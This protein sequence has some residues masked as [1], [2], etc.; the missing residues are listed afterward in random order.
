MPERD[1]TS[2][3]SDEE[4]RKRG[5]PEPQVSTIQSGINALLNNRMA[6]YNLFKF[7]AI[8]KHLLSGLVKG[9]LYFARSS[10]LNDPF[11]CRV[12]LLT[13]LENAISVAQQPARGNLEKLRGMH[14]F[15][16][17]VQADLA[18]MGV[19]SLSLEQTNSLLWAHYADNHRGVCLL[20][21]FAESFLHDRAPRIRGV[22]AVDYGPNPIRNLLLEW[23]LYP[24]NFEEFG[25]PL[26][27]KALTAKAHPWKYENE[28][29][30]LRTSYG[31]E[32]IEKHCLKQVCFGL[33]TPDREIAMLTELLKC[34]GYDATLCK[35]VRSNQS[36]F[37]IE[38]TTL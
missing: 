7:R 16:A 10:C 31:A 25:I 36:D 14:A 18:N 19:C 34:C 32:V 17:K 35:M 21:S 29:R 38:P 3:R 4:L 24:G 33:E 27:K 2:F 37:G 15:L 28:V 8:D 1:L 6:D 22:D 12:D 26:I 23:A 30:I 5:L 20:Y 9:E 13:V 11:D